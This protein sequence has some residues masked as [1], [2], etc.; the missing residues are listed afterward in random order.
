MQAMFYGCHSL[1]ELDL[2]SF[3]TNKVNDVK[4]MFANCYNLEKLLLA[5]DFIRE[6]MDQTEMFVLCDK[7]Q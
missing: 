5:E 4:Y 3:N 2:R 1:V 7:L 6:N